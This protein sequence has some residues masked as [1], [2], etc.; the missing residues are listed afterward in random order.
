MC[1]S[2]SVHIYSLNSYTNWCPNYKVAPSPSANYHLAL[3]LVVVLLCAFQFDPAFMCAMKSF[4]IQASSAVVSCALYGHLYSTR[5]YL[6]TLEE[7]SCTRLSG[8]QASQ[9]QSASMA[10]R[11]Y[12]TR[13][14]CFRV[15][16]SCFL[17]MLPSPLQGTCLS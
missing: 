7:L 2:R 12:H 3:H 15:C 14:L 4:F 8:L 6:S 1:L 11:L 17:L 13:P 16:Q 10:R 9:P 5:P